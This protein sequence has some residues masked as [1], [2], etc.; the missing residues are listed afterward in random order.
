MNLT[1]TAKPALR[2]FGC[3]VSANLLSVLGA[4]VERGRSFRPAED[5]PGHDR[6]Y[7]IDP[8]HITAELGWSPQETFKSA[9]LK[10]VK[11]YLANLPWCKRV[12]DGSYQGERLGVMQ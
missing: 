2:L 4:R 10:T 5:R 3:S 9:L 6:R 1:A 12:R 11:W 7:A 8:T